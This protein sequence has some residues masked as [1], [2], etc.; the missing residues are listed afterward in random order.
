M[1]AFELFFAEN[2]TEIIP[3]RSV[4]L[5]FAKHPEGISHFAVTGITTSTFQK[6]P[7]FTGNTEFI[8]VSVNTRVIE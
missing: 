4:L 5:Q 2:V 3:E 8:W 6:F 7:V 1:T